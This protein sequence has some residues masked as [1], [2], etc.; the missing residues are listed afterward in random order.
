METLHVMSLN[1]ISDKIQ[2]VIYEAMK[3]C[4][5]EKRL[6]VG[7]YFISELSDSD[8]SLEKIKEIL[9][10][11]FP[12]SVPRGNTPDTYKDFAAT[13]IRQYFNFETGSVRDGKI[14]ED[15]RLWY[16]IEYGYWRNTQR[17]NSYA[18]RILREQG[19]IISKRGIIQ[20][21]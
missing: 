7:G 15:E 18:L 16:N 9:S 1:G 3:T 6:C 2:P 20:N 5:N 12:P 13:A 21:P 19:I 4:C 11:I 17:G 10:K 14:K 8:H